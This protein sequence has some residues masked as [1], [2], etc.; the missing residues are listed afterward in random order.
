VFWQDLRRPATYLMLA[1]VVALAIK[2]Y[3]VWTGQD[4]DVCAWWFPPRRVI[5]TYRACPALPTI[6]LERHG[7]NSA[8]ARVGPTRMPHPRAA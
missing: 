6:P 7:P 2:N 8:R 1:L 3:F 5:P 4:R